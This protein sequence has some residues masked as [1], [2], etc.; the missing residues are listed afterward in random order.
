MKN[1]MNKTPFFF[2]SIQITETSDPAHADN[3]NAAP[4]QVFQNTLCNRKLIEELKNSA[5]GA[6]VYD[7]EIDHH[8][9]DYCM[10]GDAMYKCI[11]PTQGEWDPTCWKE[12]NVLDEISNIFNQIK[13]EW[14]V[15][16][17]AD[18]WIGVVPP[19]SQVA[20]AVG[21]L[22]GDNPILVRMLEDG[23]T[24]ERQKA[25]NKAFGILAEGTGIT[26]DGE[27]TF[28]VY[29]RPATDITVG[30]KGV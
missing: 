6:M 23:A 16:L 5:G 21:I 4:I 17:T 28:K 19:Y 18:G 10:Y 7:A 25:Y 30:L 3:I 11:R 8:M 9:G 27:V 15:T 22:S 12:T 2:E 1:Y 26:R 24:V 20:S 29:K 13:K 14:V